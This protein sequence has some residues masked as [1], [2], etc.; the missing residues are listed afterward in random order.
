[1]DCAF[2]AYLTLMSVDGTK[3]DLGG[4]EVDY[5]VDTNYSSEKGVG[6]NAPR[7]YKR[8]FEANISVK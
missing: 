5:L 4:G 2:V 8:D 7:G 1:M 6:V 3:P